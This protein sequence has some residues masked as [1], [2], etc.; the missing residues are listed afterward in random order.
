M[1]QHLL[2][3]L[4]IATCLMAVSYANDSGDTSKLTVKGEATI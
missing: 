2:I 1:K 4:S 3:C